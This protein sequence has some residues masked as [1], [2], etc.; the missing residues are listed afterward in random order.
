MLLRRNYGTVIDCKKIAS[1]ILLLAEKEIKSFNFKPKVNVVLPLQPDG[2]PRFDSSLY[3]KKKIEIFQNLGINTHIHH[4]SPQSLSD[5]NLNILL[6]DLNKDLSNNGTMIQLP[7]LS[8]S[9]PQSETE[10]VLNQVNP[11]KDIDGL[12]SSNYGNLFNRHPQCLKPATAL[13]VSTLLSYY[14]IPTSGKYIVIIGK[15]RLTGKPLSE[16]LQSHPFKATV[17]NCDVFTENIE[18]HTSKADILI[19]ASGVLH[20][21]KPHF[22]KPGA[23]LIDVGIN[24]LEGNKVAGDISPNCYEN[25]RYYTTV[26]QGVG[27]LTTASLAM[28]VVN[29]C[30][31]QNQLPIIDLVEELRNKHA[32]N[33]KSPKNSKAAQDDR[34]S[35]LLISSQNNGMTQRIRRSIEYSYQGLH[36]VRVHLATTDDKMRAAVEESRPDLIICPYLTKKIPADIYENIKCLIVHPG[37]KGDRGPSSLDWAILQRRDEWG[38]TVMEAADEMDAG[39]VW[40]SK[41]FPVL[42]EEND[43]LLSKG[44]LYNTVVC[45]TANELVLECIEKFHEYR[46]AEFAPEPLDYS[47]ADVKGTMQYI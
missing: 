39:P 40:A 44:N 27:L 13:G 26:P 4:I 9:Q 15:G 19:S 23:T 32:V 10:H 18:E 45:N 21:V 25:C 7:F 5:N 35:I 42:N 1:E 3:V 11:L 24:R 8:S 30:R 37:I 28:N 6:S 2:S 47:K 12:N 43:L 14:N 22:V 20:F 34:L 17:V 41:N 38:V 46:K 36:Q 33:Q 31:L 16:I 29:A